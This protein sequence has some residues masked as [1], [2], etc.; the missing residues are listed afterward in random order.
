MA[1]L[2]IGHID[3]PQCGSG[4]LVRSIRGDDSPKLYYSC[5]SCGQFFF[6]KAQK[7][8]VFENK[9][10]CYQGFIQVYSARELIAVLRAVWRVCIAAS[11]TAPN[12]LPK[13]LSNSMRYS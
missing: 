2:N 9:N 7:V 4:A 6:D 10:E 11:D 8:I 13:Q 12:P 1:N 5:K 3:C